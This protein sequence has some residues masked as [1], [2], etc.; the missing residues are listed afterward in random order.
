MSAITK[1]CDTIPQIETVG[2][3]SLDFC[4]AV[5]SCPVISNLKVDMQ[6]YNSS[7]KSQTERMNNIAAM[8]QTNAENLQANNE[9]DRSQDSQ[10]NEINTN[11][12]MLKG[13][14][15]KQD[16]KIES[17]QTKVIKDTKFNNFQEWVQNVYIPN[18]GATV[19]KYSGGDI[20]INKSVSLTATNATYINT[21]SPNDTRPCSADDWAELEYSSPADVLMLLGIDPIEISHPSKHERVVS[22]NPR[23]LEI[24]LSKLERINFTDV[25]ITLKEVFGNVNFNDDVSFRENVT[26]NKKLTATD[27]EVTDE[28]TVGRIATFNDVTITGLVK[29]PATFAEDVTVQ[30]DLTVDNSTTTK[31]LTVTEGTRL[32]RVFAEDLKIPGYNNNLQWII[33]DI[34]SKLRN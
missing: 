21:R 12:S 9:K 10:I 15:T 29:K 23:K 26:V 17:L 32:N 14:N 28:F 11:I 24:F 13:W 7:L 6:K 27:A 22:I 5:A 33:S 3:G 19:N 2:L 20:Y 4:G 34:Y 18:C 25:E 16:H 30:E 1:Q 8:L 31:S